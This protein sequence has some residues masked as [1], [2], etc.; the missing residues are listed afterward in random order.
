MDSLC[1]NK[2]SDFLTYN[3]SL[4]N[5]CKRWSTALQGLKNFTALLVAAVT[6]NTYSQMEFQD[7][8]FTIAA[9]FVMLTLVLACVC[10]RACHGLHFPTHPA[11]SGC[12]C[13]VLACACF[14][15]F[16]VA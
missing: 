10:L 14:Y 11:H 4:M 15:R 16:S 13:A 8:S 12:L 1:L 6:S 2:N 3:N 9:L 7:M 5:N